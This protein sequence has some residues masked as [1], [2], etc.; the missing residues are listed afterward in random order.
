M[1]RHPS[2]G[3]GDT[4]SGLRFSIVQIEQK[5]H[6]RVQ[7]RCDCYAELKVYRVSYQQFYVEEDT[8]IIIHCY[9]YRI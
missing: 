2:T 7:R 4:I 6:F 1:W 5:I 8:C 3:V 9:Q